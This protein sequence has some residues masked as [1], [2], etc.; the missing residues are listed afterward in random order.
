MVS[1]SFISFEKYE[2]KVRKKFS[3]FFSSPFRPKTPSMKKNGVS[4]RLKCSP[5]NACTFYETMDSVF[6]LSSE[7]YGMK[8]EK[9]NFAFFRKFFS[10]KPLEFFFEFCFPRKCSQGSCARFSEK[11]VSVFVVGFE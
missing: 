11:M 9:S 8:Y 1:V 2:L 3:T 7:I 10:K 6:S 5:R 4:F